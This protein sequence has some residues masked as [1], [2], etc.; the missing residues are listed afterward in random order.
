[1]NQQQIKLAQD[2]FHQRDRLKRLHDDAERKGGFTV[3]VNGSYQDEE[4]I[5]SL[6]ALV[7]PAVWTLLV[8]VLGILIGIR[9][10]SGA[11]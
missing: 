2:L 9:M 6:E 3:A 11:S 8:L 5:G 4:M 10:A 1:M 7:I